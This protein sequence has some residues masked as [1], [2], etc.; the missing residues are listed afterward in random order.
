MKS[1]LLG[2]VL[3]AMVLVTGSGCFRVSSETRALRDAALDGGLEGA[4]EKIEISLGRLAFA[5]ANFGIGFVPPEDIPAEARQVLGSVKGAEVSVYRFERR[6]GDLG[7]ML[8]AAD[9]ALEKRGCE[10]LVGVLKEDQLVA[11]YI[12]KS[13]RSPKDVCFNVL[14]LSRNDLVCVGARGDVQTILDLAMQK[15]Q[16]EFPPSTVALRQ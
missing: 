8:A 2:S 4:D 6:T 16:A 3:L 5:A 10:R 7:K 12:P 15:A 14:V 1:K 11:V 13:M 9:K